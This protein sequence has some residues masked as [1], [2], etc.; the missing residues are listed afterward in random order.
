[1][2][3]DMAEKGR[4][5]AVVTHPHRVTASAR[6]TKWAV[7][8]LLVASAALVALVAVGGWTALVGAR[9]VLIGFIVA[10]LVL[11]AATACWKRGA[12][13][14]AAALAVVLAIFAAIAG[15]QWLARDAPGYTDPALPSAVLG[16]VT[17]LLI[18]VQLLLGAVAMRAFAQAWNVESQRPGGSR[19][20]DP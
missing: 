14:L 7:I 13:P 1:M 18:P 10:Y 2:I 16:F 12:L 20:A 6:T 3:D 19:A 11:A 15:P 4:H 17:L 8:A 9:G 5:E